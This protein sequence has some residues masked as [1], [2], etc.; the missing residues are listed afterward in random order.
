M[1]NSANKVDDLHAMDKFLER[2]KIPKLPQEEI[3]SLGRPLS[4]KEV[5]LVILKSFH[6]E[7]P[8]SHWL[9]G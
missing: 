6:K 5:E 2:E 7:K 8:N 3:V 9:H 4:N 1:N